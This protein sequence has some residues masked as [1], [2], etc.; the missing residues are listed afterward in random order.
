MAALA[1]VHH[2]NFRNFQLLN[3]TLLIVLIED[4]VQYRSR[5]FGLSASFTVLPNLSLN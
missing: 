5:I 1:A 2:G 4:V 3:T